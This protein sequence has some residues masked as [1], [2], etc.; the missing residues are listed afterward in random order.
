M[1]FDIKLLIS[2]VVEK[3]KIGLNGVQGEKPTWTAID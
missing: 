1:H 3:P 2:M